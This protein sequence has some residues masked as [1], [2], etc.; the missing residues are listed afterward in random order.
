M[1]IGNGAGIVGLSGFISGAD[2]IANAASFTFHGFSYFLSGLAFAFAGFFIS[3]IWSAF[4]IDALGEYFA[5]AEKAV[6]E[7]KRRG[8][9]IELGEVWATRP[10]YYT[11]GIL[12][13][14]IQIAVI[15]GSGALFYAGSES[16]LDG[17]SKAAC[18][19]NLGGESCP[20]K[21]AF[22]FTAASTFIGS[23]NPIVLTG[24][25]SLD[26]DG[27]EGWVSKLQISPV[28]NSQTIRS[29]Y[30]EQRVRL[31]DFSRAGREMFCY[32]EVTFF[33][34]GDALSYDRR[35]S[36]NQLIE[37]SASDSGTVDI[38]PAEL[39]TT[40]ILNENGQIADSAII[41]VNATSDG[42]VKVGKPIPRDDV[43]QAVLS[44]NRTGI[45]AIV[46]DKT[47]SI[48]ARLI[49][50]ARI[51]VLDATSSRRRNQ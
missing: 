45:V 28:R 44:S 41:S 15:I 1:A 29:V 32:L 23:D 3:L 20:Y 36:A 8:K 22:P 33:L 12:F 37:F 6:E 50:G 2:N 10:I 11:L 42:G 14:F 17:L 19:K 18:S 49:K 46:T 31:A 9:S 43:V 5:K 27:R 25:S 16:V 7:A 47:S 26:E 30:F 21:A 48:C 13:G 39:L 40:V 51:P 34:A 38:R 35:S 4:R 24:V